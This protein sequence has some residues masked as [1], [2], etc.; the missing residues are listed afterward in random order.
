MNSQVNIRLKQM[1]IKTEEVLCSVI[2][3]GHF[4]CHREASQL[5]EKGRRTEELITK[6]GETIPAEKHQ[7]EKIQLQRKTEKS[8]DDAK[9]MPA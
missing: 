5:H 9:E 8:I 4:F 7:T 3:A 6:S 1:C 2:E